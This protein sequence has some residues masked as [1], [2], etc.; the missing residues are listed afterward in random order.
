MIGKLKIPI[1]KIKYFLEFL[2]H[3]NAFSRGIEV[4]VV[5]GIILRVF[6]DSGVQCAAT[7]GFRMSPHYYNNDDHVDRVVAAVNKNRALLT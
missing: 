1:W 4:I 2:E 5:K 3:P 7:G 6:D